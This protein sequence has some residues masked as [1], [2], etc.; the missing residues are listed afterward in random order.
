M[1]NKNDEV[2]NLKLFTLFFMENN[3]L[4]TLK[5][6]S[7]VINLFLSDVK[8]IIVQEYKSYDSIN[9]NIII[10]AVYMEAIINT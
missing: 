10:H 6:D 1:F 9:H 8:L 7:E 4:R 5:E 3:M 2:I